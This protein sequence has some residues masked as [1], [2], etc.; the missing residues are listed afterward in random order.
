MAPSPAL[1]VLK[2]LQ[3]EVLDAFLDLHTVNGF[4]RQ[5]ESV[6]VI[7]AAGAGV[8]SIILHALWDHLLLRLSRLLEDDGRR[9]RAHLGLH[10]LERAARDSLG[11]EL[12]RRLRKDLNKLRNDADEIREHRDRRLA[13]GELNAAAPLPTVGIERIERTLRGVAAFL[14]E[15][16][17]NITGVQT[18]YEGTDF[19][20]ATP[21]TIVELLRRGLG[22]R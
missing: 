10:A 21:G 7:N 4:F 5:K 3:H 22:A 11:A 14:N 6:E 20:G 9:G 15:I 1:A 12:S 16:E 17:R 8:F 19:G 18:D 2:R 13:H